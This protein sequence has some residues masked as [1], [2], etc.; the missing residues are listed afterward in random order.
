V[1]IPSLG[2]LVNQY[3]R[4]ANEAAERKEEYSLQAIIDAKVEGRYGDMTEASMGRIYNHVK[5]AGHKS[6]AI[7][8][9]WRSEHPHD[10]NL[11][12]FNSLKNELSTGRSETGGN[13]HPSGRGYGFN[14]LT[15]LGREEDGS[16]NVEPSLF[17]HGISMD[18]AMHHGDKHEQASIIYSGPETDGKVK[19]VH[20]KDDEGWG[21][22]RGD[23][24][25]LGDFHPRKVGQF[26]SQLRGKSFRSG[27]SDFA[28]EKTSPKAGKQG[29]ASQ[30]FKFEST[31]ER[32]GLVYSG[33]NISEAEAMSLY[34]KR[35]KNEK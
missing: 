7:M 6:F 31:D 1:K 10:V 20:L 14:K 32:Y 15:G 2:N 24:T 22:K 4:E 18:D 9:S 8:T 35:V 13:S 11:N 19:L 29:K 34:E 26:W 16:V 27:K 17:V 12:R 3:D 5:N 25:D 23:H 33:E 30:A 28:P 21:V